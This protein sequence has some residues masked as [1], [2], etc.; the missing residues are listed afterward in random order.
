MGSTSVKTLKTTGK[1]A[2]H[3]GRGAVK[4]TKFTIIHWKGLLPFLCMGASGVFAGAATVFALLYGPWAWA[5][6]TLAGLVLFV[7]IDGWIGTLELPARRHGVA[8]LLF[9]AASAVALIVAGGITET[10]IVI[11]LV[12]LIL[13]TWW[14]KGDAYQGHRAVKRAERRMEGLIE[15]LAITDG[16]RVTK[17]EVK[18]DKTKEWNVY[19]G[20]QTRPDAF[21]ADTIAHLLKTQT[22]RVVVRRVDKRSTRLIKVVWLGTSPAKSV[23]RSHPALEAS[24]REAGGA[25]EPGT[26]SIL[27]GLAIGGILGSVL[28]AVIKLY[29]K[30]RDSRSV[31]ILGK[32]GSGKTN[33]ASALLLSLIA[34]GDVAVGVCDVPKVGNLG[35]PFAQALHRIARTAD[36]LEAD[37][38]GL[39]RLASDRCARLARGEIRTADG[40]RARNWVPTVADPAIVYMIDELANTMLAMD[41]LQAQRIWDLLIGLGQFVRQAGIMLLP[42]SQTAKRDM[43]ETDFTSQMGTYVVHQLKK[44]ADAG[45]I[46]QGLD[47]NFLEAGL[48]EVGMNLVGDIDGGEPSKSISFNMD[49]PIGDED[50]WNTVIDEYAQRRPAASDR[51]VALLGWGDTLCSADMFT[52]PGTDV[53]VV[54]GPAPVAVDEAQA[55]ESKEYDARLVGL[56]EEFAT[57]DA[58]PA[59]AGIKSGPA[60]EEPGDDKRKKAILDALAERGENGIG[61]AEVEKLLGV[62]RSTALRVLTALIDDERITKTGQTKTS[63]YYLRTD[64]LVD[65]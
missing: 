63:R 44:Q 5:W 27:D 33:T 30:G 8:F 23:V 13:A 14:W 61:R 18:P 16:T 59:G 21:K 57:E 4:A 46:W 9:T 24:A 34:C 43:V 36:E 48:P 52:E 26:R 64:L 11:T 62:K 10:Y 49:E 17:T 58:I 15:K 28:L 60:P 22:D 54:D 45:D 3:T 6:T 56:L 37:L 1:V 2:V 53:A 55:V 47:V 7:W 39:Y 35:I 40:K 38:E 65:A 20:D 19:L 42:M 32:S 12:C 29:T 50:S 31:M 25:W 51:E 41:P